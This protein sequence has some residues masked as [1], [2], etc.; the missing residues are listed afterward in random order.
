MGNT[1]ESMRQVKN[2]SYLDAPLFRDHVS[3]H[4]Q[5]SLTFTGKKRTLLYGYSPGPAPGKHVR[6]AGGGYASRDEV[7]VEGSHK[8]AVSTHQFVVS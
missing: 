2:I 1:L 8:E 7:R 3:I 5:L 6:S 4:D